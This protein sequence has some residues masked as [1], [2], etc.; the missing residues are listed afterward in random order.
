MNIGARDL[1]ADMI[2]EAVD[3]G[4]VRRKPRPIQETLKAMAYFPNCYSPTAAALAAQLHDIGDSLSA[5]CA[6][7]AR[8]PTPD[9]CEHL[10]IQLQ[11][12]ARHVLA[13]REAV[14]REDA[15]R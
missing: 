10:S 6:E 14:Q 9:R 1:I 12:A 8:G 4:E 13:L 2:R 3:R 5:Q 11:G 15:S 7:L